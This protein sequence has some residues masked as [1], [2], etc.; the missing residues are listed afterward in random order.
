MKLAGSY[1]L[2]IKKEIVWQAL[3]NINI[4]KQCI[5]GCE[6]FE[7]ES[8]TI[9]N[10]TATNQIGPMN[11]TFSGKINLTNIQKNQS[12][13]L[14]GEGQ[15]SVGFANGSA[16]IILSEENESTTLNYEVNVNV[17]GKIAQLGSRLID[18]VAKKMTDYFFGR[19]ADIVSPI[20]TVNNFVVKENRVKELKSNF[21]NNYIYSGLAILILLAVA[22]FYFVSR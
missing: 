19:F 20:Q 3:N 17:G 5:P 7:K 10:V 2:N 14:S 1:K 9:F 4:L 6:S 22:I 15:S 18:G 8:D 13:T 11:A 12:Y 16:D 21:L